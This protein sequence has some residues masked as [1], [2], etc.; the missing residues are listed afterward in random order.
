MTSFAPE[1]FF[2]LGR[3][4]WCP[5]I[6]T[7]KLDFPSC[8]I[9]IALCQTQKNKNENRLLTASLFTQAKE[10][11]SEVSVK[12]AVWRWVLTSSSKNSKALAAIT[13][14]VGLGDPIVTT[15]DFYQAGPVLSRVR[16]QT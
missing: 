6:H 9:R 2:L 14:C 10:K 16:V 15:V 8:P 5:Q 11:A 13:S 7:G 4:N 3:T 1:D 12:H